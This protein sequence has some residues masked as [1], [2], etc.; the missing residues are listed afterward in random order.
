MPELLTKIASV[1][2]TLGYLRALM[3]DRLINQD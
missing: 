2:F 1:G 3:N